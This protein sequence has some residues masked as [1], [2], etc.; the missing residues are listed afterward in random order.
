MIQQVE[1][2]LV[3]ALR[4]R[5]PPLI[6]KAAAPSLA[7][8]YGATFG[9]FYAASRPQVQSLQGSIGSSLKRYKLAYTTL[10]EQSHEEKSTER[11]LSCSY[12][13]NVSPF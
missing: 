10:S 6:E 13:E 7:L 5:I 1:E 4:S 8:G 2:H 9:A 11:I 3:P 12:R